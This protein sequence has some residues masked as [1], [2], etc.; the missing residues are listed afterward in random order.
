[1][2]KIK[3]R[4]KLKDKNGFYPIY[5]GVSEFFLKDL[6]ARLYIN[7]QDYRVTVLQ[8]RGALSRLPYEIGAIIFHVDLK[9]K[10]V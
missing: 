1:M 3:L 2:L 5:I 10:F 9:R 7:K 4:C 6:V 8:V